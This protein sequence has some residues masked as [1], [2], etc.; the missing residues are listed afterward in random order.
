MN[1]DLY[2]SHWFT[3][4][5]IKIIPH[6]R[7][8]TLRY[9]LYRWIVPDLAGTMSAKGGALWSLDWEA[10]KFDDEAAGLAGGSLCN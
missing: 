8:E 6:R 4:R 10:R 7:Y 3:K 1:V 2:P 9:L 5:A